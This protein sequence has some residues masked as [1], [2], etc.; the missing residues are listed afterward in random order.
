MKS[1]NENDTYKNYLDSKMAYDPGF[2][3]SEQ[4]LTKISNKSSNIITK[5][6]YKKKVGQEI[7]YV[8]AKD[9]LCNIKEMLKYTE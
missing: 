4:N 2:S 5:N 6:N 3:V 8:E 1:D 7:M 9:L